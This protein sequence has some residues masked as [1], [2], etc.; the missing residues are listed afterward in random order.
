MAKVYSGRVVIPGD[1]LQDYLKLMEAAEA[2]REPFR[3]QMMALR[4]GFHD[5]LAERYTERT[6]RKHAGV[7]ELFVNFI[8]R[9]TDVQDIAEITRGMVNTHFRA[10]WKR[11]V[12]DSSTPDD[13]RVALG[14]FFRFLAAEKGIVN[15]KVLDALK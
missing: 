14:K 13:L 8:C 1:K 11:K 4:D 2:E 12:W 9:Q 15:Q 6:A 10:W 3:Q 5:Y 7:V